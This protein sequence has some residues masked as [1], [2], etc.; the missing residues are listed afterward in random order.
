MCMCTYN[1]GTIRQT[2]KLILITPRVLRLEERTV[3]QSARHRGLQKY[4]LTLLTA[5][6]PHTKLVSSLTVDRE[7]KLLASGG[8]DSTV[9]FLNVQDE[10]SPVGFIHTPAPV[11]TM[12]W[13]SG[14]QVE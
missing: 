11:T 4:Q 8:K 13:S 7:G 9:F 10:Y 2:V 12:R 5:A 14:K 3:S 1:V 6:K